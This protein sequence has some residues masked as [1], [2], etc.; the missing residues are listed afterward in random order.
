[1]EY[2]IR[3][4]IL[5]FVMVTIFSPNVICGNTPDSIYIRPI[6]SDIIHSHNGKSYHFVKDEWVR[7]E[8]KYIDN[9]IVG[10]T[11]PT[12]NKSNTDYNK[13]IHIP[14]SDIESFPDFQSCITR[15]DSVT[16]KIDLSKINRIGYMKLYL[17]TLKLA[18]VRYKSIHT[19]TLPDSLDFTNASIHYVPDSIP[20]NWIDFSTI[21]VHSDDHPEDSDIT[22]GGQTSKS[23]KILILVIVGLCILIIDIFILWRKR[24]Q[25]QRYKKTYTSDDESEVNKDISTLLDNEISD[26]DQIE[27]Y[28]NTSEKATKESFDK[29]QKEYTE[30]K[31]QL[32]S[33][34]YKADKLTFDLEKECKKRND[35]IKQEITNVNKESENKIRK[36]QSDADRNVKLANERAD[37]AES[38]SRSIESRLNEKFNHERNRLIGEKNELNDSL[39]K[40]R[41]ELKITIQEL[42]KVTLSLSQRIR[43]V[44]RLTL[45]TQAFNEKLSGITDAQ[46]YCREIVNLLRLSNDIQTSAIEMLNIDI[47]DSYFMYKALALFS[48]RLNAINML[49]FLTEIEMISKT[50]FVIKGTPLSGINK[51]LSAKEIENLAK[52]YFFTTYLKS[53]VDALV[54]L[55][56]SFAGIHFLI[57]DLNS[58]F[59]NIFKE[60][61]EQLNN[62]TQRLGI[63]IVTVRLFDMVGSNTDL[64]ATEIDAGVDRHG[65]IIEIENCKV[66][67]IGG[68]PDPRRIVVKSQI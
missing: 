49:N 55:N 4:L 64:S 16:L 39:S 27:D 9:I 67:L 58:S 17:D 28:D 22:K 18:E 43:E 45:E 65:A 30:T 52:N 59:T 20:G 63:Q 3:L 34:L 21:S 7:V 11:L 46:S 42:D 33:A 26:T 38:L 8:E 54:V 60:Y 48:S 51:S 57:P 53:Y 35:I 12:N 62:V 66:S 19:L 25:N 36:I 44:E 41:Q 13:Q 47:S 14:K 5:F 15:P 24:K 56:E 40:T 32:K 29:L 50:G 6:K 31:N 2:K 68:T 1:M 23:L 37:K 61:R 10:D